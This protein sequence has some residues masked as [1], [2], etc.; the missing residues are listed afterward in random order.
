MNVLKRLGKAVVAGF[1]AIVVVAV[2]VLFVTVNVYIGDHMSGVLIHWLIPVGE[3]SDKNWVIPFATF[4]SLVLFWI[5]F[6]VYLFA[7]FLKNAEPAG[8]E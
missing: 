4:A 1:F 7:S 2:V 6:L 8:A 5:G 3:I